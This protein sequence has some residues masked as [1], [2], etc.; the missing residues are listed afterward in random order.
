MLEIF[1]T[2]LGLLLFFLGVRFLALAG[3]FP[4]YHKMQIYI[5]TV[6]LTFQRK[7]MRLGAEARHHALWLLL[8]MVH[9]AT[10]FFLHTLAYLEKS[11]TNISKKV[12]G[13]SALRV[14]TARNITP[15]FEALRKKEGTHTHEKEI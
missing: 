1:F 8:T 12:Q 7:C 3:R 14:Y 11:M 15:L 13:R 5:D 4:Y 10:V 2:S 9:R 6:L